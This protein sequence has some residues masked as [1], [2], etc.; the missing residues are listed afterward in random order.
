MKASQIKTNGWL[1]VTKPYHKQNCREYYELRGSE[2]NKCF[3]KVQSYNPINGCGYTFIRAMISTED[4]F[5]REIP[6]TTDFKII[7]EVWEELMNELLER[8]FDTKI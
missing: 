3:G 2:L 4:P 5:V 1:N 7:N 6:Y 8:I